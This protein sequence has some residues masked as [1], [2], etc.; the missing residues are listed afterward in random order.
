MIATTWVISK[1]IKNFT[2]NKNADAGE[3]I[4]SC[5][6]DFGYTDHQYLFKKYRFIND[7]SFQKVQSISERLRKILLNWFQSSKKVFEFKNF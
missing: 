4:S 7:L 3:L 5:L 1:L 2:K 6:T